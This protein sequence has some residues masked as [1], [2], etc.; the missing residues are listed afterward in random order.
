MKRIA[1][2]AC[3]KANHCCAAC[4]CLD[5][6][7]ER[8]GAFGAYTEPLR[9]IGF[10]RCEACVPQAEVPGKG[11]LEKL[12]RLCDQRADAVHLGVC[13]A[14]NGKICPY[15]AVLESWLQSRGIRIV[16]GT[17][18]TKGPAF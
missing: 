12:E 16:H 1:I 6:F 10:F 8:T 2:L 11:D 15:M 13:A 4:S 18:R 17:H 7:A 3:E 5:A 14:E 9:L